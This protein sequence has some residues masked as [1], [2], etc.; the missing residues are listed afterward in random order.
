MDLC[1][2]FRI[3]RLL[4]S[5]GFILFVILP[6]CNVWGKRGSSLGGQPARG[7]VRPW[8]VPLLLSLLGLDFCP[9][10]Y[11]QLTPVFPDSQVAEWGD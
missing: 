5:L 7:W 11:L 1:G 2:V 10:L 6:R 8:V 9:T 3:F 4:E